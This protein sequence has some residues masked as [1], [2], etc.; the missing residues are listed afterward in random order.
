MLKE[1][2]FFEYI[3]DFGI[4]Y[5]HENYA[6]KLQTVPIAFYN[7]NGTIESIPL[8]PHVFLRDTQKTNAIFSNL[9]YNFYIFF[10]IIQ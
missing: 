1:S 8:E 10:F 5:L 9:H 2:R 4:I 6:F 3:D 7:P